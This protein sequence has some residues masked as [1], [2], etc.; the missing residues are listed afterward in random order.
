MEE[1]EEAEEAEED[2]GELVGT[3]PKLLVQGEEGEGRRTRSE[4]LLGK[5]RSAAEEDRRLVPAV[6][7]EGE[8]FFLLVWTTNRETCPGRA[9][10]EA[11]WQVGASVGCALP[12]ER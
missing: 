11:D 2:S 1:E 4:V 5:D 10:C 9:G 6:V 7:V 12:V 3:R 8:F